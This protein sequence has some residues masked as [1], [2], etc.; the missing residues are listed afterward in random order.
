MYQKQWTR[1]PT[2]LRRYRKAGK[3]YTRVPI[4]E[5]ESYK[6]IEGVNRAC[7]NTDPTRLVHICDRDADV[8]ELFENCVTSQT[9]F[10][11]RAVH[12]RAT[13][14]KGVKCFTRLSRVPACGIYTL[15]MKPCQKRS[16]RTAQIAVKFY[17][18]NLVPPVAKSAR[19]KPVEVYVVSA[20]EKNSNGLKETELVNWKLLTDMPIETFEHALEV[21]NWYQ[22]RWNIGTYFKILKS[23]FG[24]DKSRLRHGDR[25][26]KFAALVSVLAWRVFWIT[27][28]TRSCPQAPPTLCYEKEE[29][30]ALQDIE[31]L[32][33]RK[34]S[35]RSST[36]QE[37]TLAIARLGGYLARKSDP[38][39]G[40]IVIWRGLQRLHDITMLN[41]ART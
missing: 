33:G 11:V 36:L 6:W 22:M 8:Y 31:K 1:D 15:L 19:C 30:Q 5:K 26:K 9:H 3:N 7:A 21:I 41:G 29:I 12:S 35:L 2:N 39:P 4:E 34:L 38:P 10:V 32:Q 28:I 17:K 37:F 27:T 25:I 24:L 14:R 40:N 18:V 20:K 16:A 23:G 13:S